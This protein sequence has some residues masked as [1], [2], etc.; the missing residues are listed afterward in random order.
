V[1]IDE[2]QERTLHPSQSFFT[3]LRT[4]IPRIC[5]SDPLEDIVVMLVGLLLHRQILRKLFHVDADRH[6][7]DEKWFMYEEEMM[8]RG[9]DVRSVCEICRTDAILAELVSLSV[10]E[11]RF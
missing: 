7:D 4:F 9:V 5:S 10:T 11:R 2:N 8:V 1:Q 3:L 6:I